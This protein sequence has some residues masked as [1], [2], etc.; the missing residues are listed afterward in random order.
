MINYKDKKKIEGIVIFL[1]INI[2]SGGGKME[3]TVLEQQKK[4]INIEVVFCF[5]IKYCLCL[6]L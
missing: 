2:G 5:D 4:E 1:E 6:A 3:I